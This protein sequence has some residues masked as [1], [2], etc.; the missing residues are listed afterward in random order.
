M[1]RDFGRIEIHRRA[2]TDRCQ[3]ASEV[4]IGG[5]KRGFHQRRMRDRARDAVTLGNIFAA[6]Y[7]DGHEL[8]CALAVA[9]DGLRE[10]EA[11]FFERGDER[12]AVN[13]VE[14]RDWRIARFAGGR[15]EV[16]VVG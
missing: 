2:V 10:F 16:A 15:D 9:H 6:A 5:E 4:R 3:N 1:H 14:R 11:D 13:R 7:G 12:C 8:G